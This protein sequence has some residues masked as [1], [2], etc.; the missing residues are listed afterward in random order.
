MQ[1]VA[2]QSTARDSPLPHLF[3]TLFQKIFS[4]ISTD[5][6]RLMRLL[7]YVCTQLCTCVYTHMYTSLQSNLREAS[8]CRWPCAES[9][10]SY[11]EAVMRVP[12]G[13]IARSTAPGQ[14]TPV[15]HSLLV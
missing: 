2:S 5:V 10:G 3:P 9:N 13:S 1:Q 7:N 14:V 12:Y 8:V 11:S 4:D 15:F 6:F